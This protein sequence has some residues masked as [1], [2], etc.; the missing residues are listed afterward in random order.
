MMSVST[1]MTY[2]NMLYIFYL[3]MKEKIQTHINK[4]FTT[5]F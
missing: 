1:K 5:N 3:L 4:T 2:K